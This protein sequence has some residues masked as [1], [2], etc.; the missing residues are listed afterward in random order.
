LSFIVSSYHYKNTL[1]T[2]AITT[3]AWAHHGGACYID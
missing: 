2:I 1:A 3:A